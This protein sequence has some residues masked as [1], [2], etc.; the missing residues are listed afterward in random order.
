MRQLLFSPRRTLEVG[1][2]RGMRVL[3]IPG[4]GSYEMS[5]G[6]GQP[7]NK[8][9]VRSPWAFACMQIRGNE[10][11]NLPW[12]LVDRGSGKIIEKHPVIK[13]LTEFG[14][15]SNYKESVIATE[16][17]MCMVAKAFWLRDADKL[18]R[19][20]AGSI[21]VIATTTGIQGFEQWINGRKVNTFGR[22]EM[23]YFHEFNP[24]NDLLPGPSIMD[25]VKGAVSI[26]WESGLYTEAFFQNDATPATFLGTDQQVSEDE[27]D[28]ILAWWN[29]TFRGSRKAHKVAFGDRGLKPTA[30]GNTMKDNAVTAIHDQAVNSICVGFRV[31]RLLAGQFVEATYANA[32]EA[33]VYLLENVIIPRAGYY[34]ETINVDLVW[35][36][37]PNVMLKYAP[38]ELSIL[39]EGANEKWKRLS[40]ALTV[41]AIDLPFAR[42]EMGWPETAAP[43][44]TPAPVVTIEQTT[45]Q[46]A[47]R[48]WMRKAKNAVRNGKAPGVD[49]ETDDIPPRTQAA[50]RVKLDAAKTIAEI[51]RAFQDD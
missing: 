23:V 17:E 12:H 34:E 3:D 14:L 7:G 29:K 48:A 45:E 37:D 28:R 30:V 36:I 26:E 41:G 35:K 19:L 21:K 15:E 51:D 32:N 40:D 8:K 25:V 10:L 31:P 44:V 47:L 49:F 39:Q 13:L 42:K 11:A 27:M 6:Q 43:A 24:D 50:I 4:I 38:Q 20:N 22:D 1:T 16:T 2:E 33:R 18:Q 46:A 9:Y 5:S